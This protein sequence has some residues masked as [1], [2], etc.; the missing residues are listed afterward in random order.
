MTLVRP[1]ALKP[2]DTI[3][4]V[5]P[6]SSIQADFLAEG[7]LELESL[8]FGVR[9]REDIHDR[10]RY[11]AGGVDR[12]VEEFAQ[13][14]NDPSLAAVF[15]ARGGY[16]SAHLLPHLDFESMVSEPRIFCGASDITMLLGALEHAGMVVF[17]GPMVATSIRL[18]EEGYNRDVLKRLMI[19]GEAVSFP[20]TGCEVLRPGR[21]EGRLTGGCI[22]LVVSL[23]GT[24]WEVSTR[25]SLMVLEDI[26][27]RPYQVD[28]MLTQLRQ[29][30][31][32]EGVQ[33]F[34]FGE[35][36]ECFQHEE[37]DYTLQDVIVEVLGDLGVPILY[38]FPTGH[39]TQPNVPVPFGVP[40]RLD[41]EDS[42]QGGA[43]R[44]ELLEPAVTM[45]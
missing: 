3:G 25:G 14:M 19:E 17:H 36:L 1:A 45:P 28:R 12:R 41:L 18:G 39:S 38:N 42:S 30:G 43:A 11:L 37:Q 34:V 2:G 4:L 7:C 13:M 23:L 29:A 27:C 9:F 31:K 15:C 35:M 40:A 32:F 21:A 5:T 6:S 24:P 8:G 22:S 44:F 10:H 33:G 26:G 16:G 20:T